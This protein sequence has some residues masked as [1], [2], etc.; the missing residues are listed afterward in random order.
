MSM[1]EESRK[2]PYKAILFLALLALAGCS[3]FFIGP[4]DLGFIHHQP[5]QCFH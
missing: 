4:N 2:Y 1:L 5:A 3:G